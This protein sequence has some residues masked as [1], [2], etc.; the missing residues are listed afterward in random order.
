MKKIL[1]ILVSITFTFFCF[2]CHTTNLQRVK[3]EGPGSLNI[4]RLA[5]VDTLT[6]VTAR[7]YFT[8]TVDD[9][10]KINTGTHTLVDGLGEYALIPTD[11]KNKYTEGTGNYSEFQGKNLDWRFPQS[12]YGLEMELSNNNKIYTVG[13]NINNMGRRRP[14]LGGNIGFGFFEKN[15]VTGWRTNIALSWHPV[16]YEALVVVKISEWF[17]DTFVHLITREG[18]TT[19]ANFNFSLALNSDIEVGFPFGLFGQLGIGSNRIVDI[20]GE[21]DTAEYSTKYSVGYTNYYT[22]L[23]AGLYRNLTSDM[24]II[25]GFSYSLNGDE[26][27]TFV[28]RRTFFIQLEI[29]FITKNQ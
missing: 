8:S 21:L 18:R 28:S 2:S 17:S 15:G 22:N 14:Y 11:E 29:D 16:K 3:I 19:F 12:V 26:I 20:E 9:R 25:T 1:K 10:I 5:K 4:V 23:T 27:D 6:R 7:P 13:L 24:R